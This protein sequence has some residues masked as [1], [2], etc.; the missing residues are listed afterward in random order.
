MGVCMKRERQCELTGKQYDARK[1]RLPS[2]SIFSK[3][4]KCNRRVVQFRKLFDFYATPLQGCLK[5]QGCRAKLQLCGDNSVFVSSIFIY[6]SH[7]ASVK[8]ARSRDNF[9][10]C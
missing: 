8:R 7:M 9:S 5:M 6:Q 4:D 1:E 2:A 10:I 3:H